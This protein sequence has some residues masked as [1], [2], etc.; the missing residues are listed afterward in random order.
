MQQHAVAPRITVRRKRRVTKQK[1]WS[2]QNQ[3]SW[4]SPGQATTSWPNPVL[5]T[6][7]KLVRGPCRR[8]GR[9]H[10]RGEPAKKALKQRTPC[11]D[12][13]DRWGHSPSTC[14]FRPSFTEDCRGV[15]HRPGQPTPSFIYFAG[16]CI[17]SQAQEEKGN[18]RAN[19]NQTVTQTT[20]H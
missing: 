11:L 12:R 18:G 7:A 2:N 16:H 20:S 10:R 13:L 6:L 5:S 4:G 17:T 15:A 3:T 19:C 14:P 8:G 9:R 1:C